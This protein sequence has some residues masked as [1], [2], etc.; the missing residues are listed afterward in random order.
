[1]PER[2]AKKSSG[3]GGRHRRRHLL[4]DGT[5]VESKLL[6]LQDVTVDTSALTWA[7]SDNSVETTG[8]ELTLDRRL[9]LSGSLDTLLLL[10]LDGLALLDLLGLGLGLASTADRGAVV[11][12]VPL[13]ER[14]GIDLDDGRLGEGVG[15][16]EFVVGRVES[17]GDDADLAGDTLATPGEV[18]GVET[19]GAELA[20]AATGADEVDTLGADTGVG[21]LAALLESS[22]GLTSDDVRLGR[23]SGYAYLFLR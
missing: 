11:G 7:G 4:P 20:V 16:D 21:G 23:H 10:L 14:R 1:M 9:H 15:T 3:V 17:D 2:Q 8:L 6:A 12:L 18:A 19:Q 22:V 13:T 5:L